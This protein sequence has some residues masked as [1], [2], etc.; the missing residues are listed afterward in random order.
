LDLARGNI[1]DGVGVLP[2]GLG[3]GEGIAEGRLVRAGRNVDLAGD[4]GD[5]GA[6]RNVRRQ[7][8]HC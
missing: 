1:L 7:T 8:G 6:E 4:R 3:L 5:A 2:R